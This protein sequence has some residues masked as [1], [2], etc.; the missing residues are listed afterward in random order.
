MFRSCGRARAGSSSTGRL[1]PSRGSRRRLSELPA[2]AEQNQPGRPKR[3]VDDEHG[4]PLPGVGA[5]E[6]GDVPQ[7]CHRRTGREQLTAGLPRLGKQL[8]RARRSGAG[9]AEHEEDHEAEADA[10]EAEGADDRGGH[11]GDGEDC[12]RRHRRDREV[13]AGQRA[14]EHLDDEHR[15]RAAEQGEYGKRPDS[16][17]RR[18]RRSEVEEEQRPENRRNRDG[19][20]GQVDRDVAR[21]VVV[22]L[23]QILGLCARQGRCGDAE[24]HERRLEARRR[25]HQDLR[26][27]TWNH[28]PIRLAVEHRLACGGL[29]GDADDVEVVTLFERPKDALGLPASVVDDGDREAVRLGVVRRVD[30]KEGEQSHQ[31]DATEYGTQRALHELTIHQPAAVYAA[32]LQ[33]SLG[34]PQPRERDA[35]RR[36]GHVVEAELVAERHAR[37]LYP[38]CGDP[39]L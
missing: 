38:R 1:A 30:E 32:L 24:D 5:V 27:S 23:A 31:R 18:Q 35:V 10:R 20:P 17:G 13:G 7:P 34:R 36:A 3:R 19:E 22:E 2:P 28:C 6:V 26:R 21:I 12:E 37:R 4:Q 15:H 29:V 8:R 25:R 11:R 16:P 39:R 9:V 14:D 33:R